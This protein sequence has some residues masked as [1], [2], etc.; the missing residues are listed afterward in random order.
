[1]G[2]WLLLIFIVS[3]SSFCQPL[4]CVPAMCFPVVFYFFIAALSLFPVGILLATVSFLSTCLW[5]QPCSV[6]VF[7]FLS[8]CFSFLSTCFMIAA[9]P[10]NMFFCFVSFGPFCV[11]MYFCCFLAFCFWM[12]FLPVYHFLCFG[13]FP[14][15]GCFRS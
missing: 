15:W 3:F 2:S 9:C 1:M 13:L 4:S 8:Q 12:P 14:V 11:S 10:V 6:G 7:V 5:L